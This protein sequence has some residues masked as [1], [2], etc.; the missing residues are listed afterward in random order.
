MSEGGYKIRN[1]AAV[2]FIT[3]AVDEWLD[4]FTR[5]DYRDIVL[6]SIRHGQNKRG[7]LLHGWCVMSNH[8]HLIVAAQNNDL[9]DILRDFKKFTSKQIIK[10]IENNEHE[11][12]REWMLSIFKKAGETNSRNS[13]FQFWRQDNQ[14]KELYS[15]AFVF[16]KLNYIHS[17]SVEAGIVDKAEEY[18]Y[19]SARDYH[20]TKKCGLLDVI[21]L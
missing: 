15:P 17:N 21:F 12:R 5:K 19:S 3:F 4:V 6:E 10:A 7:L 16:Q 9:S 18:L 8:L 20:R 14:P 11:S 13:E 1:Q 2:H